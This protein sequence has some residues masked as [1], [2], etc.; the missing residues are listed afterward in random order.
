M[1][2]E[3]NAS[4]KFYLLAL[5]TGL[6]FGALIYSNFQL[7]WLYKIDGQYL[8]FTQSRAT[9]SIA[10]LYN[11]NPNED[12][13]TLYFIIIG[14]SS[15]YHSINDK[16]LSSIL[17]KKLNKPVKVL[18]ISYPSMCLLETFNLISAIPKA[19]YGNSYIINAWSFW[20]MTTDPF[21]QTKHALSY[22][23][24]LFIGNKELINI[25][26][27][28]KKLTQYIPKVYQDYPWDYD[29]WDD[30]LNNENLPR[31]ST[32]FTTWTKYFLLD[33]LLKLNRSDFKHLFKDYE[34]VSSA[35]DLSKT[36]IEQFKNLLKQPAMKQQ[37]ASSK[38]NHINDFDRRYK[39]VMI[40]LDKIISFNLLIFN[41]SAELAKSKGYEYIVLELPISNDS[42]Q[43][44]NIT[45]FIQKF[46]N[47]IVQDLSSVKYVNYQ[48]IPSLDNNEYAWW[49]LVHMTIVG[50]K[51]YMEKLASFLENIS[52]KE[53]V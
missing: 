7:K 26:Q 53:K 25:L 37:I 46:R 8:T 52:S 4:K 2:K 36:A 27:K 35:E 12:K 32:I 40:N 1:V 50:K 3:K 45:A 43:S 21:E 42:Y 14:G 28:D 19:Q 49:D 51:I 31:S 9:Q 41:K 24:S 22:D 16:L 17:S 18:L 48:S 47:S 10:K 20:K 34:E 39:Y 5:L 23:R 15:A 38:I 6:L 29:N 44:T 30:F 33:K 11:F 13:N